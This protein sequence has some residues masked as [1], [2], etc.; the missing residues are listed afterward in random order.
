MEQIYAGYEVPDD[1]TLVLKV[2]PNYAGSRTFYIDGIDVGGFSAS[3]T[4]DMSIITLPICKGQVI[5]C[6]SKVNAGSY[7]FV[8]WKA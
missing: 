4:A 5:K 3:N 1:G 6:S 7:K 2:G 8:P